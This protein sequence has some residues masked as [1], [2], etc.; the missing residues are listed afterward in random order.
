MIVIVVCRY[1]HQSKY[2]AQV[3]STLLPIVLRFHIEDLTNIDDD[4]KARLLQYCKENN[5]PPIVTETHM[6]VSDDHDMQHDNTFVQHAFEQY[7][8]PYIAEHTAGD[9]FILH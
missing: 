1:E 2:F 8:Y 3:S 6:V 7:I 4:E 9:L 5:K